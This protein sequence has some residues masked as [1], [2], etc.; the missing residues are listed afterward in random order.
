M[1]K[2]IVVL[3]MLFFLN[4]IISNGW[5]KETDKQFFSEKPTAQEFADGFYLVETGKFDLYDVLNEIELLGNACI[6]GIDNLIFSDNIKPNLPELIG[7]D[8]EKV[9]ASNF[10]VNANKEYALLALGRINSFDA[11]DILFK[12]LNKSDDIN[13]KAIS[14]TLLDSEYKQKIIEDDIEPKKELIKYFIDYLED[15]TFID[16]YGTKLDRISKNGIKNWIGKDFGDFQDEKLI[17]VDDKISFE[18][19]TKEK[20]IKYWNDIEPKIKWNKKTSLFEIN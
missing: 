5:A 9:K 8:G 11:F 14:L 1:I 3:V 20:K 10:V 13:L 15:S 16:Y 18:K 12:V 2:K 17:V 19:I 6:N 7:I 4:V